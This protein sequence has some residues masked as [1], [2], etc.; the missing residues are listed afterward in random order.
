[1]VLVGLG[2]AAWRWWHGRGQARPP[3]VT[4]GALVA[5]WLVLPSLLFLRHATPVYPHYFIILFPAPFILAALAVEA[6]IARWRQAWLVL[7]PLAIVVGQVWLS[8]ALLRF[9]GSTA[10]PGAF[11]TPL[12]M[13]LQAAETARGLGAEVVVVAEGDNPA[14]DQTPAVFAALLRGIPHRFVDGRSTAV[15]PAGDEVVLLWPAGDAYGW[16]LEA[17][18]QAWGGGQWAARIPLR[19]GEGQA[20]IAQSAGRQ[21]AVPSPRAASALLA[22]GWSCWARLQAA[23]AGSCGGGRRAR[24]PMSA[25]TSSPTCWMPVPSG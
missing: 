5:L 8:L 19:A 15:F 9:V 3:S 12:S 1:L 4:A 25:I 22:N 16:P 2:L 18:Y 11:G 7:A 6:A 21:P 14:Q 24:S 20:L 13:L 17:L 23:P 10:T